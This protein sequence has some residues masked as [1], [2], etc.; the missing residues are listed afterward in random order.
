MHCRRHGALAT[1]TAL[2][3]MLASSIK[4]SRL[5]E[6]VGSSFPLELKIGKSSFH[7]IIADQEHLYC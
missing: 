3:L 1:V 4:S 2:I 6:S 5:G 7:L